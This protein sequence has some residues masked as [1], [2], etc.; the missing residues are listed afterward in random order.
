MGVDT[1]FLATATPADNANLIHDTLRRTAEARA[2]QQSFL[3]D[4]VIIN[5]CDGP[6]GVVAPLSA[7]ALS[8]SE[9]D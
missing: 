4:G 1:G 7:S 9:L 3:E 8:E 2:Q 5:P 6:C